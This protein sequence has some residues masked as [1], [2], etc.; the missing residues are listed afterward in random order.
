MSIVD[1]N[2]NITTIG[3]IEDR[4]VI[5][6]EKTTNNKEIVLER[7][8]DGYNTIL[9]QFSKDGKVSWATLLGK[10]EIGTK[11]IIEKD[12]KYLTGVYI[13]NNITIEG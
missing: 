5:P 2:N 13:E 9:I 3:A 7:K 8:E 12:N 1:E 11:E 4:T 10:I 6:A